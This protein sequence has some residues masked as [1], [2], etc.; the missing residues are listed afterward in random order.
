MSKE[1]FLARISAM[2]SKQAKNSRAITQEDYDNII[3]KLKLLEKKVKGKTIPGF[4]TN[5]YN[6][7]NTHEILTV[8]KNGQIFERLVRPSKKDPNKKLF[9]IT[10]ENMFE[11]VYKVHQDSQNVDRDVMHPVLMETYANITQPQC[12][13]MVDSCQQCQKKKARNKKRIVVKVG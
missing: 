8:E 5:D 6:L 9:Y 3:M 11:P 7:P 2:R 1:I 13:A 10:I 12:Q 4:T